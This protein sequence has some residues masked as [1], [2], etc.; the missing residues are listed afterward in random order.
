MESLLI[1]FYEIHRKFILV[2]LRMHWRRCEKNNML[3]E[4]HII[5]ENVLCQR[6]QCQRNFSFRW[7]SFRKDGFLCFSSS[8]FVEKSCWSG[9]KMCFEP[10]RAI[11]RLTF[12][13]YKYMKFGCCKWY[14]LM[15][16]NDGKK[17]NKYVWTWRQYVDD[18]HFSDFNEMTLRTSGREYAPSNT[19]NNS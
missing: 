1:P 10:N 5:W 18:E 15:D 6:V 12:P 9:D 2:R 8:A 13:I 7:L 4:F 17:L 3:I 11:W 16:G 14:L 19:T